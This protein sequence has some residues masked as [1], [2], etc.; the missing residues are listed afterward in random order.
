MSALLDVAG[1]SAGYGDTPI[2]HGV[3]VHVDAG[4]VVC[5]IGPN[6]AGKSTLVK[7]VIGLLRIFA[8]KVCFEGQDITGLR[9]EDRAMIGLGYVP[10][11]ANVFATLSVRENIVLGLPDRRGS[12]A[13]CD[14]M[15]EM[16]PELRDKL[17]LPAGRLSGGERQMLAFARCLV[18]KPRILLLDEPTAALSPLLTGQ[19]FARI[20]AIA[21][22]GVAVLLVEQNA[23]RALAISDRAYVLVAGRNAAE[24]T[25]A[26]LRSRPD[27]K[28]LYLGGHSRAAPTPEPKP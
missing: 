10:Q 18:R 4:E 11:V 19:I 25:A 3:S 1:L 6:G 9:T 5:V 13:A 12:A 27:I 17:R 7:A 22:G 23:L 21:A 8:G 26:D 20:A 2:L 24:G 15:L 28:E 16:F 14:S